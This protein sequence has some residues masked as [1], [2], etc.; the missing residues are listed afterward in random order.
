VL[1]YSEFDEARARTLLSEDLG[2]EAARSR[3]GAIANWAERDDVTTA[4]FFH[5]SSFRGI[6]PEHAELE[7]TARLLEPGLETRAREIPF[8]VDDDARE[9]ALHRLVLLGIVRDYVV[10]WGGQKFTV[11]VNPVH[12]GTIEA[13]LTDFVER[14]QPGRAETIRAELAVEDLRKT[15]RSI[16]V[17]GRLLIEFIYETIERSRRRSLREMWSAVKEARTDAALR[18][19]ILDFLSEGDV[20]PLLEGLAEAGQFDVSAWAT[21][22]ERI[23]SIGEARE[24]RGTCARL[25]GSYPDQPGLLIGRSIVEL[26]DPDGELTDFES[27]LESAFAAAPRYGIDAQAVNVMR[28]WILGFAARQST[29]AFAVALATID[30]MDGPGWLLDR[31]LAGPGKRYAGVPGV[32]VTNLSRSLRESVRAVN[33]LIGLVRGRYE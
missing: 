29:R 18:Q 25:L 2:L 22:Y 27:N 21:A 5:F 3:C 28:E 8:G 33:E 6:A 14:S 16:S 24:W 30:R 13:A 12:E 11:V 19:R 31:A 10:D 17:C 7:E 15:Q 1:V 4:L 32:A 9:R 23:M 20:A 26:V